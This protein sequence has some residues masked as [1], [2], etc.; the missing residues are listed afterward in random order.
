MAV[1]ETDN[2]VAVTQSRTNQ[3]RAK[4]AVKNV[5]VVQ[6]NGPEFIEVG[7]NSDPGDFTLLF[8]NRLI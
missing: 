1:V 4:S 2:R 6:S 8:E 3:V 5:R 7:D